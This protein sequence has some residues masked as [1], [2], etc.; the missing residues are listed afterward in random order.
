MALLMVLIIPMPSKQIR[1]NLYLKRVV[2]AA[3]WSRVAEKWWWTRL[4]GPGGSQLRYALSQASK[5][6][7]PYQVIECIV[8]P[9]RNLVSKLETKINFTKP[10]KNHAPVSTPKVVQTKITLKAKSPPP[11][12][13]V[14]INEPSPNSVR[15]TTDEVAG[16]G[17]EKVAEPP[18][19]VKPTSEQA[20]FSSKAAQLGSHLGEKRSSTDSMS[21]RVKKLRT[22]VSSSL[23]LSELF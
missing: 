1:E 19:K 22:G 12:K 17:E 11:I 18:P 20:H 4:S 16:K 9:R 2:D 3:K 7:A 21:S 8:R 13:G 5:E 6:G 14:V 10:K 15:L 23:S